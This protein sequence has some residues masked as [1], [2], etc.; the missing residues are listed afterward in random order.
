VTRTI[1]NGDNFHLLRGRWGWEIEGRGFSGDSYGTE[2]IKEGKLSVM[3]RNGISP[4]IGGAHRPD[5]GV[6]GIEQRARPSLCIGL[7]LLSLQSEKPIQLEANKK[8]SGGTSRD[9]RE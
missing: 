1:L 5:M 6:E 2:T 9:S 3:G 7:F 4:I 8:K